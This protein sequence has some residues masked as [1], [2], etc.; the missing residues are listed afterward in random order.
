MRQWRPAS[1]TTSPT[2][3]SAGAGSAV[4]CA[5]EAKVH[6]ADGLVRDGSLRHDQTGRIGRPACL[7]Q[8]ARQPA[9]IGPRH[10]DGEAW[11]PQVRQ[12]LPVARALL[13]CRLFPLRAFS[14]AASFAIYGAMIRMAAMGAQENKLGGE[15]AVGQWNPA[16]A[17]AAEA[18]VTPGT[19]SKSMPARRAA[20]SLLRLRAQRSADRRLAAARR[21]GLAD[22]YPINN[23]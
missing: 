13:R 7:E 6:P 20:Q 22:A 4:A 2:I 9:I 10:I 8:I 21:C 19:I 14:T 12:R 3:R 23:A 11:R 17:A 1:A 18:A 15:P 16:A 5:S